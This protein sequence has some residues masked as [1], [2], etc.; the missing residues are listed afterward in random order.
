MSRFKKLRIVSSFARVFP[1]VWPYRRKVAASL[2]VALM[3]AMFWSLNLSAAFP[4]VKVLIQGQSLKEYVEK[5]IA[6]AEDQIAK[7][8]AA[9]EGIER[10]QETLTEAGEPANSEESVELLKD[11]SRQQEKLITASRKKVLMEGVRS[12][13]IPYLPGDQFDLLALIFG[14]LLLAMILKGICVF[15]QDVLIGNVVELTT[16]AIRKECFRHVLE[17]DYQSLH[18]AGSADM[19]SRF[20]HDLNLLGYGLR[21]L[22][23]KVVREPLKA[24]CCIVGAFLVC[25]QL[26][27]LALL[28]VP[29]VGLVFYRIGSKLKQASRRMMESMSR[30]YKTLE[31]TLDAIKVVIAFNG[32]RR[33]RQRFHR[34]SKEYYRKSQRIIS[35]DALTSPTTEVL[36]MVT[37]FIALLPG[38]YLVLRQTTRI[39]GV[40][41]SSH[42]MDIAELTLLYVLLA[43]TIDPLRKLST[44]YTKFKRGS[45][46]AERVFA[47]IDR[48]PLVKEPEHPQSLPRHSR[49][50]EFHRIDFS[51]TPAD[52]DGFS[53]P[54][55][56][57]DIDLTVNAGEVVV[58]V[59]ENGSGKSTLVNL[60][61]RFFDPEHGEVRIDGIDIRSARLRD[62]RDQI[63]I[64]T[65]ETVLFDDTLFENIRYG[66]PDATR[67]E[68]EAAARKA[69]VTAFADQLPDGLSTPVGEKGSRLSGGQ[70]Q[71]VA[72]ARALLR[73]PAILILDEA[74]S[75]IDAQSEILIH[76]TLR[77]F[78][79]NRTTFIITHSVSRS[80]LDF[81]S[82]IVVLDQGM[83]VATGTHEQLM[84][85]CDLYRKLYRAQIDQQGDNEPA[86][87][88]IADSNSTAAANHLPPHPP[89][90]GPPA[91]R[92]APAGNSAE[93]HE[94]AAHIIPLRLAKTSDQ[95][96]NNAGSCNDETSPPRVDGTTS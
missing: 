51:Y 82:R 44:T 20:T 24:A 48:K 23:G 67:E 89:G 81:V 88:E 79:R 5:E 22:G 66:K 6:I 60:L 87:G 78:A 62:L 14:C 11:R 57:K 9:L 13:I 80:M 43:G 84:A 27:L 8:E 54:P 56:L 91:P 65:Q 53:R 69:H 93:I 18:L 30:V 15:V 32:G 90:S 12:Y 41:L 7:R 71:R 47:L 70:R 61:P 73:D 38:A 2:I 40:T 55:V 83:L 86:R 42:Q 64:V 63:G 28:F 37:A 94:T 59:G 16:M 39:W 85:G 36:G 21:L 10:R 31:E 75:A 34:E 77:R 68:V 19:M 52:D 25:W 96:P 29:L 92:N 33:H 72:L 4:I 26:T 74:T 17:L 35:I 76:E 1:Y 50:V 3:V 46:A 45:A 49:S 95:N 58:V